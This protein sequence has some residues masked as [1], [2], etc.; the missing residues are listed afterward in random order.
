M[1]PTVSV[2]NTNTRIPSFAQGVAAAQMAAASRGCL[3]SRRRIA[4]GQAGCPGAAGAL[5]VFW[6]I[7]PARTG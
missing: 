1:A 5:G 7:A 2:T 4:W 6:A 3:V